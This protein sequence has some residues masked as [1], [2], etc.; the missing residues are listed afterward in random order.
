MSAQTIRRII[1]GIGIV[2]I[3][4]AYFPWWFWLPAVAVLTALSAILACLIRKRRREERRNS[5]SLRIET[6]DWMGR[7]IPKQPK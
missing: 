7:P 2:A 3:F 6:S 1:G 4:I 5:P